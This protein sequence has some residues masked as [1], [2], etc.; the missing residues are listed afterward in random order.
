MPVS[1][2]PDRNE[3]LDYLVG[4][5]SDPASD[6]LADHL[7]GCRRC[8]A[9]LATIPEAEDTLVG[10][11][12]Q[13][14][15]ADPYLEE[16]ACHAALSRAKGEERE[17]GRRGGEERRQLDDGVPLSPSPP[18]QLPHELGEYQLLEELGHGSMGTV[19]KARHT[20]LDRVVAIKILA[21]GRIDDSR[22]IAR[23][24]REMKAIGRLEH[25]N[26]VHAHDAR[27]ID[28]HPVLVMEYVEGMDLGKVARGLGQIPVA[29]A[30]E[31]ARQAALA[32]QYAHEHG[33]VHRDV[34]PS[35]LMLAVSGQ[36]SAF[37]FPNSD[38]PVPNSPQS[39]AAH[40]SSLAPPRVKLLDLGL[41]RVRWEPGSGEEMTGSGQAMGTADYMAPEQVSD[42]HDVDIRADVYS[43]GCTLYRLVC[44][45]APFGGPEHRGSFEKMAA[46]VHQAVPPI[47]QLR[48]E[49]P[50]ELAAVIER[51]LAK[52]PA[53][54]FATPGEVAEALAPF[55]EY[56]AADLA[57]LL[58]RA[59][60]APERVAAEGI[61]LPSPV[62]GR[63]VG[64]EG[65]SFR[66]PVAA[67]ERQPPRSR[68]KVA[69]GLAGVL[70]VGVAIG[71][72]A[73]IVIRIQHGDKETTVKVP[74][75]SDVTVGADGQVA[76]R[77][78]GGA[79]PAAAPVPL[80]K[81]IQGAWQVVT[82]THQ[83]FPMNSG[84]WEGTDKA[85]DVVK[86]TRVI[87]TADTMKFLGEHVVSMV[88]QYSIN[89]K[90]DPP[91][92]DVQGWGQGTALGDLRL[93]GDQLTLCF[94]RSSRPSP[95]APTRGPQVA[96]ERPTDFWVGLG[97]GKELLGLK[98]V[99]RR[100]GRA[101][102][103]SDPGEMAGRE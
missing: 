22:A 1:L 28:G 86:T 61:S 99:R 42:S 26:I 38:F 13:P 84:S 9:E 68:V 67:A 44:G 39:L 25:P 87:I 66:P 78:P 4:R 58:T 51:M 35:N 97:S 16:P 15:A 85:E 30:C 80:D 56:A 46:H 102:R 53:G 34:K 31:L 45:Q 70:L 40:P 49:V 98:R 91:M 5:L 82:S 7:D 93:E 48:P 55:C 101:R 83:L 71:L 3:L 74:D 41:A 20:K 76:I 47:R 12:R 100:C 59:I 75:G 8:Q 27:E 79:K 60:E 14:M 37:S 19:Y 63:G 6:V 81:A 72:A 94:G 2:C 29:A 95:A 18:L 24:E 90:S 10:R 62:R 43:L 36:P 73:G 32:L 33:L 64:G 23:F 69:L 92:I 57:G 65:P 89:T 103:G 96:S 77:L 54:R 21:R 50:E 17:K 52:D 88:Y 11:L